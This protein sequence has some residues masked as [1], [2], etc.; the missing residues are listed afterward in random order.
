[1]RIERIVCGSLSANC[2]IIYQKDGGSAYIIDPGYD[3]KQTQDFIEKHGLQVKAILLTHSHFDHSGKADALS[4]YYGVEVCAG[5][6]EL[7]RYNGNTNRYV[8][9]KVDMLFEGGETLDLDG[10]TIEVFH[11]PGHT[12]GGL[13][14]YSKKSRIVFT[15]DIIFNVDLGYTHF[16]GGSSARMKNS[17]KTVV[18]KWEND[19]TIYPGHGDSATMK[20]VRE[21]NNEFLDMIAE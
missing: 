20:Y 5:R 4:K 2:Y 16:P 18:N 1:M 15:G 13:C 7:D 9:S 6:E 12:A 19:I 3:I 17:L 8:G 11:T 10:E 14:F 21:V